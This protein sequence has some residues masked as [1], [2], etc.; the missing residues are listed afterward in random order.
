MPE[1][2]QQL[3]KIEDVKQLFRKPKLVVRMCAF[4]THGAKT[5]VM[6]GKGYT[7]ESCSNYCNQEDWCDNFIL[8]IMTS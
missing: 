1:S 4:E 6:P 8:G 3:A 2:H 5:K 7:V